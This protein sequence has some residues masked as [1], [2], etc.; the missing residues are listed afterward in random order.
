[1]QKQ[2]RFSLLFPR[3]ICVIKSYLNAFSL[4]P[5]PLSFRSSM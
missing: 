1:M 5:L 3:F 4:K 2:Q